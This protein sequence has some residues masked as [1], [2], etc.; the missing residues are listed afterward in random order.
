MNADRI[1]ALNNILRR[2]DFDPDQLAL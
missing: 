2:L 1:G